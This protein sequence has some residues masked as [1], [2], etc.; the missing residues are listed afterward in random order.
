MKL[1]V[2]EYKNNLIAKAEKLILTGFP[3][4]II[5]LNDLLATPLFKN[6]DFAEVNQV[7]T[8]FF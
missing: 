2:E 1:Q 5:K 8:S 7:I 4:K 3:E 6:R